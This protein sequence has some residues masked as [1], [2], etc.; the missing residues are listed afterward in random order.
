MEEKTSGKMG[1][2]HHIAL[3]VRDLEK[4]KSFYI[5]HFYCVSGEKYINEKKQYASYFLKFENTSME[6]MNRPDIESSPFSKEVFGWAHIAISL[7]SKEQVLETLEQIRN[8]GCAV[9]G[10]PRITG[11]GFF[12][13]VVA[14]PE[15]NRVELTI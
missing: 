7:G 13:A 11:D 12:E 9:L 15:G 14:D 6:I 5:R 3:W 8:E 1:N 4:I 10:E 2:I